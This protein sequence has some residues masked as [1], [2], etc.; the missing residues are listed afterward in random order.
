M[1]E[2][3]PS[4]P[5]KGALSNGERKVFFALQDNL[6]SAFTGLHSVALLTRPRGAQRLFDS[7]IDF[8]VCHPAYGLLGGR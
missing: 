5:L 6:P 8:V 1:A 4:S 2:M 3:H 7:E